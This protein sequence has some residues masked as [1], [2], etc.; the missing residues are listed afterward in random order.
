MD[1][2]RSGTAEEF[3]EKDQLLND[4]TNIIKNT[5]ASREA[6]QAAKK[7]KKAGPGPNDPKRAEAA[8]IIRENS[9]KAK[10]A[11]AAEDIDIESLET[12]GSENEAEE[13][14]I[15]ELLTPQKSKS[16]KY[17][18]FTKNTTTML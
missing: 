16:S 11:A 3:T 1:V 15:K 6:A 18:S 10:K 7:S 8:A 2:C 14:D 17:N 5:K 4:I 13:D 9:M 12:S